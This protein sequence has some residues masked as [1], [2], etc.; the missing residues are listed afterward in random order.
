VPDSRKELGSE[1]R[2]LLP[3]RMQG[4]ITLVM[5]MLLTMLKEMSIKAK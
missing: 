1:A 2:R 3:R 5:M 4:L